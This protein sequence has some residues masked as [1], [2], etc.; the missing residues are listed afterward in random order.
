M[1]DDANHREIL[2]AAL[3]AGRFLDEVY[4]IYLSEIGEDHDLVLDIATLH[5]DGHVD[6]L[7]E[8]LNLNQVVPGGPDL[9]VTLHVFEKVLPLID[10]PVHDVIRTVL[11]INQCAVQG[12]SA[13]SI[14]DGYIGFC[15]KDPLRPQ[16][17]LVLIEAE[18]GQFAD[19]LPAT[20][21]AGSSIDTSHYLG[22][23][24]RLSRHSEK[25]LRQRAV[26]A[27]SRVQ[28]PNEANVPDSAITA[29]E[30]AAAEVDSEILASVI[31]SAFTFYQQDKTTE[32]RVTLLIGDAL[33]RSD[34]HTLHAAAMLLGFH[35]KEIPQPLLDILLSQLMN[36]NPANRGTIE[37]IDFG[38]AHLLNGIDVEKGLRFLE[39]FLLMNS[40]ILTIK[41]FRS[42]AHEI[43]QSKDLLSK[44]M[45]RWFLKGACI[46]CENI[47]ELGG[48]HHG[49][50]LFIDI[51]PAELQTMDGSQVVFVA[52]KAIGYFFMEPVTAASIVI[53]LMR[54]TLDEQV[55]GE[56]G[57]LLFEPLLLNY[58]RSVA[59]YLET[60]RAQMSEKAKEVI[61]KS[62]ASISSYLVEL[63]S[64]PK[65]PALNPSQANQESYRRHMSDLITKSHNAAEKESVFFELVSRS[66]LLYGREVIDYIQSKE[67]EDERTVT[68]MISH[69]IEMEFPRIEHFDAW[70]L[71]YMIRVFRSE[72]IRS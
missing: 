25:I 35:S 24:I 53:S 15:A 54:H 66:T 12:H 42:V 26:F 43:C 34:D 27:L 38:I 65:L 39:A 2:I 18:P 23:V 32:S 44:V 10:A 56:L 50:N 67:G 22:E 63:R 49:D 45:T 64:I 31:K 48:T 57:Q 9:F 36:V 59:E 37:R 1:T 30:V 61:D 41:M 17:A 21:A 72:T 4:S 8:F 58:P 3:A 11:D 20:I 68:P 13:G 14:F 40:K 62:L 46:L 71:D 60:Q 5:N 28:W 29:L 7:T 52:R 69:G 55:L 51:D 19:I 6:V 16:Q 47:H 70:G 33:E